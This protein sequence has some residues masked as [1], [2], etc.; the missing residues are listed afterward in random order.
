MSGLVSSIRDM[1]G[2][3]V[4][5]SWHFNQYFLNELIA[6]ND[7]YKEAQ[8]LYLSNNP[9]N[10]EKLII[11]GYGD[12]NRMYGAGHTRTL[13]QSSYTLHFFATRSGDILHSSSNESRKLPGNL[14]L[15][16]SYINGFASGDAH[17][18]TESK[19]ENGHLAIS[20][21]ENGSEY[22]EGLITN[23]RRINSCYH[24][25]ITLHFM[26]YV[27]QGEDFMKPS[28]KKSN[29]S[30]KTDAALFSKLL[31]GEGFRKEIQADMSL[32]SHHLQDSNFDY[33]KKNWLLLVNNV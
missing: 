6:S 28:Y 17:V 25:D 22:V 26:K 1:E 3:V 8:H 31:G 19:L 33:D 7:A 29:A 32:I 24:G 20:S 27:G 12:V 21:A 4:G 2:I 23:V 9:L 16:K 13:L 15:I 5:D 14:R 11:G 30:L 10:T 18:V